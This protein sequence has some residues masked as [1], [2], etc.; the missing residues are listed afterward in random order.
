MEDPELQR[1]MEDDDGDFTL[2][3]H[4]LATVSLFTECENLLH[5]FHASI[6]Q[7]K[8]NPA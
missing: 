7:V 8:A 5:G 1:F 2:L 6:L 3:V 4:N